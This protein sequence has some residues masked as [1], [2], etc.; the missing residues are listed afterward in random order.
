MPHRS[1]LIDGMLSGTGIRDAEHGGYC[2]AQS[3]GLPA[4]LIADLNDWLSRYADVHFSGYADV[5]AIAKLD[6]EGLVL[7]RR[8]GSILPEADV[9]YFSNALMKQLG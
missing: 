4:N 6:E 2:S 3:L 7:A 1:L 8:V 9:G 5:A